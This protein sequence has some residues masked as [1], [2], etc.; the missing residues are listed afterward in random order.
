MADLARFDRSATTVLV[1]VVDL[2][3]VAA[4]LSYG[5]ITHG[6]DPLADPFYTVETVA[7]F[8]LGW[9]LAAPMLGVYTARVRSSLVETLLSVGLAWIVAAL[10]GV[11]LR[12]TPWL[13]GG[14]PPAF[15]LVTVAT[16][17]A[18][19]L[20]WRVLVVALARLRS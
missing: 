8:L 20:P 14:A 16:G 13:V 18:T 1:L 6:T 4:Q 11:G 2:A 12:A 3:I 9:L 7:P 19:L 5:L 10:I 15:V 17:L